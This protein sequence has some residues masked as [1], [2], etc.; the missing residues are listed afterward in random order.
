[1]GDQ[2]GNKIKNLRMKAGMTQA[3]LAIVLKLSPSTIG[4]YEQ[5]RREPDLISLIKLAR[6]FQVSTDYLLGITEN[7]STQAMACGQSLTETEQL[8]LESY[9]RNADLRG[10]IDL[11]LTLNSPPPEQEE[12][13]HVFEAAS[14]A[15]HHP[16][17]FSHISK[18]KW[19]RI[20]EA[21]ET[22]DP[23]L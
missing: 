17:Q 6:Y 11:V 4:M 2:I 18:K 8:L 5:N 13:L 15:D 16:P 14:S 23:L 12:Q 9:R 7:P 10:T 19:E 3:Q 1:M 20:L 22:D 21:P